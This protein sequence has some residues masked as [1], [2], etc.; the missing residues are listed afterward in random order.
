M[1]LSEL[2][3]VQFSIKNC[4][5]FLQHCRAVKK[6][7]QQLQSLTAEQLDDIG[8]TEAVVET[9]CQKGFFDITMTGEQMN[10]GTVGKERI[11]TT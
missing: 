11:Q 6:Q 9:E 10:C 3:T 4:I 2:K 1:K 7:R 5:A 8:L